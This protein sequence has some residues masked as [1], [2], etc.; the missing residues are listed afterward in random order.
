MICTKGSQD[1]R[2]LPIPPLYQQGI[3]YA[4]LPTLRDVVILVHALLQALSI[5]A[6]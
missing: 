1:P 3:S 2:L 5:E 4:L 6:F